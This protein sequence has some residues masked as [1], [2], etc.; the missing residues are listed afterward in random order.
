MPQLL[1]S[2]SL[3]CLKQEFYQANLASIPL[4]LITNQVLLSDFLPTDTLIQKFIDYKSTTVFAVFGVELSSTL[5]SLSH[6]A[7][8][9]I[10]SVMFLI[11]SGAKFFV[12]TTYASKSYT[13]IF[14]NNQRMLLFIHFLCYSYSFQCS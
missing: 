1:M 9:Q 13:M 11:I 4:T 12:Y 14:Q 2:K 8:A 6:S 3:G 5:N 7:V 10:K